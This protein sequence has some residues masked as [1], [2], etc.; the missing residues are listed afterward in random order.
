MKRSHTVKAAVEVPLGRRGK[1]KT[2]L[3]A[4]WSDTDAGWMTS[5]S[6]R[7]API[8]GKLDITT[9]IS[10]YHAILGTPVFY[11]YE[12][13][14]YQAYPWKSLRGNGIRAVCALTA[15]AGGCDMTVWAAYGPSG[16][17]E[18]SIGVKIKM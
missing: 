12:P 1:L 2:A 7:F 17:I 11:Y 15:G 16:E 18:T 4:P 14:M 9:F 3:L 6:V 5:Q 10:K 8:P 13:S